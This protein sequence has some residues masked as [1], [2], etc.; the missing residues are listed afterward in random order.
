MPTDHWADIVAQMS[1]H[2]NSTFREIE[3]D[4]ATLTPG[5]A[6]F[7]APVDRTSSRGTSVTFSVELL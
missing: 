6:W 4:D 5:H 1:N 7:V 3:V 2:L